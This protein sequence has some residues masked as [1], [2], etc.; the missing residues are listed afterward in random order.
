[1]FD[2]ELE[3]RNE[4]RPACLTPREHLLILKKHQR[5]VISD[6][7][8]PHTS[9]QITA[10]LLESLDDTQEL[11]L[12]STIVDLSRSEL[13]RIERH[14]PTLLKE[15]STATRERSIRNEL[16]RQT[17]IRISENR[18]MRKQLLDGSESL[19]KPISS[20]ELDTLFSE[21]IQRRREAREIWQKLPEVI[22]QRQEREHLLPRL[23]KLPIKQSLNFGRVRLDTIPRQDVAQILDL[24]LEEGT[25]GA[26]GKQAVLTESLENETE[27]SQMLR[28]R[29]RQDQN[30]IQVDEQKLKFRKDGRHHPRE[31]G[32]ALVRPMTRTVHS[33]C[34]NGVEK[35]VFGISD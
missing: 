35:A 20:R 6:D 26:L 22:G 30:V 34:P 15:D 9:L 14:G 7:G 13:G 28:G 5:I 2:S 8:E 21:L 17:E 24:L 4:F 11:L 32:W 18:R 10:P 27:V 12:P 33:K 19:Q 1:V 3:P 25:F 29:F 23:R 31:G 16:K